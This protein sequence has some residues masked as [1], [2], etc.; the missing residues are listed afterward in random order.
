MRTPKESDY[1]MKLNIN[2]FVDMQTHYLCESCHFLRR[3]EDPIKQ[4]FESK[5]AE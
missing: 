2:Y 5:P 1:L 4:D 3:P